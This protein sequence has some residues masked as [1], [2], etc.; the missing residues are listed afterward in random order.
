MHS[1][2]AAW[3]VAGGRGRAWSADRRAQALWAGGGW[4]TSTIA[5]FLESWESWLGFSLG[6]ELS[7]ALPAEPVRLHST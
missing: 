2:S 4:A 7:G 5:Q 3:G 1:V 6:T